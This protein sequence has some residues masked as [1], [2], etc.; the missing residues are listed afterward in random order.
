MPISGKPMPAMKIA[1]ATSGAKRNCRASAAVS[2]VPARPPSTAS[3]G[4]TNTKCRMPLYIAGRNAID[5][6]REQ[7]GERDQEQDRPPV[8]R[9]VAPQRRD[10]RPAAPPKPSTRKI[11]GSLSA[12]SVG[13]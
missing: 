12:N 7:R 11:S 2:Q 10:Q 6:E 1:A 4:S 5:R 13:T 9:D 3:G 8:R